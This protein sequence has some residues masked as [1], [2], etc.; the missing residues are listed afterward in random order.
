[1]GVIRGPEWAHLSSMTSTSQLVIRMRTEG[2]E[3]EKREME[4]WGKLRIAI[5]K[6]FRM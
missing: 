6:I 5:Q 2:D 3:A 1:M 4:R